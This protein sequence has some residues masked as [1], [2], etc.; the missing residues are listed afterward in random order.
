MPNPGNRRIAIQKMTGLAVLGAAALFVVGSA[1]GVIFPNDRDGPGVTTVRFDVGTRL[2]EADTAGLTAVADALL[3]A[4]TTVAVITGHTGPEGDPAAN[5]SLSE[6]RAAAVA[7]RLTA[8]GVPSDRLRIRGAGGAVPPPDIA[9]A[10]AAER[11][12]ATKRAEIRLVH[13]ALLA[14]GDPL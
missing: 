14:P 11:A 4:P 7:E 9:D 12:A 1:A 10:S 6:Q 8:A 2:V 3:D 5:L 13:R